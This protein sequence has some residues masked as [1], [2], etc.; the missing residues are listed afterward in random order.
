MFTG[1]AK[2]MAAT[3]QSNAQ[4]LQRE[5]N[6]LAQCIELRLHSYFQQQPLDL[7][8]QAAAQGIVHADIQLML[9][10]HAAAQVAGRRPGAHMP[11]NSPV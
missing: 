6:W 7:L 1:A 10:Q 8:Q 5:L 9:A 3:T 2:L 4:C 11:L